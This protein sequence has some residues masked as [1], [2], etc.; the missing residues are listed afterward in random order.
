MPLFRPQR[1]GTLGNVLFRAAFWAIALAFTLAVAAEQ[2]P[3]LC[4]GPL[5]LTSHAGSTPVCGYSRWCF[6]GNLSWRRS[7]RCK[8]KFAE[9]GIVA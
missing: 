1:N 7:A 6:L 4:P 5:T 8:P 9:G 2:T 3:L